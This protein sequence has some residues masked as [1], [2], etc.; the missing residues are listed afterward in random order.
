MAA[1]KSMAKDFLDK[2]KKD[3]ITVY[4]AQSSFFIVIAFFP[5]IMLLLT[6]IQLIP[7]VSKADVTEMMVTIMPDMLD[8]L[9]TGII[10]DLYTKSPRTVLS[11]SAIAALW[12]SSRGMLG[13]E[14][15]MNR[16]NESPRERGYLI[17]RVLCTFYTLFFVAACIGSLLFLVFGNTIYS[18]ITRRL[19]WLTA[20]ADLIYSIRSSSLLL[21]LVIVFSCLYKWL[22]VRRFS[23]LSQIPGALLSTLGWVV[24]SKL[25]SIYI[26]NFSNYS[27]MYGSLTAMVLLML[28]LY[29]CICILFIGAELNFWLN[30]HFFAKGKC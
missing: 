14:Q 10:N 19:P 16:V 18:F 3:E 24:F 8:S 4:A 1:L 22:P 21:L 2:C 15:G 20:Y 25:Y 23:F 29:F 11:F 27:Y 13:I 6:L 5:F 17:R 9:V 28:W 30:R 12:S 26:E 7:A